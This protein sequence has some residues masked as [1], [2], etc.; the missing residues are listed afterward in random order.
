MSPIKKVFLVIG[1][2]VLAFLI[3]QL[4][5]NDGG[6]LITGWNAV[7]DTV[8]GVWQKIT[9]NSTSTIVPEWGDAVDAGENGGS[10]NEAQW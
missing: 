8:N 3:W 1:V 10:L 5:F 7:A 6:V 2:L 4:V 9:G